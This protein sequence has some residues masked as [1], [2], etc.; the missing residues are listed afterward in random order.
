MVMGRAI[1]VTP[2]WTFTSPC[3]VR[4]NSIPIFDTPTPFSTHSWKDMDSSGHT[5]ISRT[6]GPH[7]PSSVAY[8]RPSFPT[9]RTLPKWRTQATPTS[10]RHIS[11]QAHDTFPLKYKDAVEVAPRSLSAVA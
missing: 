3:G 8:H 7:T 11:Q 1:E 5:V 9:P 4:N 2:S 6:H 10:T